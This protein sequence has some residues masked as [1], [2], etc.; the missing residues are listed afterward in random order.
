MW[1]T[2]ILAQVAEQGTQMTPVGEVVNTHTSR[3]SLLAKVNETGVQVYF[4]HSIFSADLFIS[5]NLWLIR[6]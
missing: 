5:S 4:L 1:C 3:L 6:L 2:C